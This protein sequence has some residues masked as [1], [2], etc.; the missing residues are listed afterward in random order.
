MR[1][2]LLRAIASPVPPLPSARTKVG[3]LTVPDSQP[4]R[5]VYLYFAAQNPVL[6]RFRQFLTRSTRLGLRLHRREP[7]TKY[8]NRGVCERGFGW[9]VH[10]E[11]TIS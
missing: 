8:R 3:D 10:A 6:L 9:K 5:V 1:R 2:R 11:N 7:S 4:K